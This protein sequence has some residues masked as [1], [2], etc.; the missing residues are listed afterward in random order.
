M[1]SKY[2]VALIHVLFWLGFLVMPF[3]FAN[4]PYNNA[5][6]W[7]KLIL[8]TGFLAIFFY[9]NTTLLIPKLLGRKKVHLYILSIIATT[10][11]IVYL[12]IFIEQQFNPE[13]F[14]RPWF[15][16]KVIT[17][18]IFSSLIVLTIGGGLKITKEWF[19]NEQMKKEV[20]SEKLQ[21]ELALMK[22]QINP[23]FLFNTLNNI[24]SLVRKNSLKSD[25][26]IVKLSQ[27]MRYMLDDAASEH[28]PLEK[29]IEY[30]QNYIDL[31]RLRLP[32]KV[33]IQFEIIRNSPGYNIPPMLFIPFV[34]N[35]F[36]HGVSYIDDSRVV[37]KLE[38]NSNT[39]FFSVYNNLNI[40]KEEQKMTR[41][42]GGFG[43]KNIKKRLEI[44]YPEHH[45]LTIV[46]ENG[47]YKVDLL[48]KIR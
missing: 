20:E 5:I 39:L 22:S 11:A 7:Y 13:M 44:L 29:E 26:A 34:E 8:S 25:A 10:A 38:V 48:I 18:S 37:I 43:L 9:L 17:D 19:R 23:H 28:V 31:Q 41:K 32:E 6:L 42:G 47:L 24:R 16:D 12:R 40:R 33:D 2:I 35:A 45:E 14:D 21:A 27:L 1:S 15:K 36:K 46:S 30:L 4:L 3:F